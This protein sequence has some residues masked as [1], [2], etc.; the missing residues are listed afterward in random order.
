[1]EKADTPPLLCASIYLAEN[2]KQASTATSYLINQAFTPL[3]HPVTIW[4]SGSWDFT[5]TGS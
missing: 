1:M 2:M 4:R 5:A 3:A